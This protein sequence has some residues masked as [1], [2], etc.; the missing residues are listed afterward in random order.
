MGVSWSSPHV[1]GRK[2]LT[3]FSHGAA[4]AAYSLI[5]LFALSG[6]HEFRRTGEAAF[7]YE[8]SWFNASE[9]NW[10][11][12]R[13]LAQA[14]NQQPML[15]PYSNTWCHGAPGI[16]VS[17]IRAAEILSDQCYLGEALAALETTRNHLWT[18]LRSGRANYSLCHGV[19]GNADILL[20]AVRSGVQLDL[21]A[22]ASIRETAEFGLQAYSGNDSLWPCGVGGGG[23]N[24]SLML[25]WAGI[26]YFY[27]RLARQNIPSPLMPRGKVG[28]A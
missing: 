9:R 6:D 3:G 25:G 4:G 26:G 20:M 18:W 11:D 17:R 5:E 23:A 24:P 22:E 13:Q 10:P 27:L 12:F 28:E 16:A 15:L 14:D 7:D 2:N 21:D 19:A 1:L 8:R